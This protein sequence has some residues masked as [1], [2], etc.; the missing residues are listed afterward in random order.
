MTSF[1]AVFAIFDA[2]DVRSFIVQLNGWGRNIETAVSELR[3][4]TETAVS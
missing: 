4:A 1:Q 3:S 2:T